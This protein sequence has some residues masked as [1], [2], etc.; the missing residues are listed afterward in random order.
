[1]PGLWQA[2][3]IMPKLHSTN[4]NSGTSSM[5]TI[6]YPSEWEAIKNLAEK[7][8]YKAIMDYA[9]Y[10]EEDPARID[11]DADPTLTHEF[12]V[13]SFAISALA[14]FPSDEITRFLI[15]KFDEY[16]DDYQKS[17]VIRAISQHGTETAK[18]FLLKLLKKDDNSIFTEAVI[19]GVDNAEITVTRE[20][21][22]LLLES[23][24]KNEEIQEF[25]GSVFEIAARSDKKL[26]AELF[27]NAFK[28][29]STVGVLS[30]DQSSLL[31][32]LVEA[33]M[34]IDY[35]IDLSILQ[36]LVEN[37]GND[38]NAGLV[39]RLVYSYPGS[40]T[41]DEFLSRLQQDYAESDYVLSEIGMGLE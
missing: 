16:Q 3:K 26:S 28:D 8:D 32:H 31:E 40:K 9:D 18:T 1:M 22:N 6:T 2:M 4:H 7:S 5:N 27:D 29:L 36:Q 12:E 15:K 21:L 33:A 30:V 23:V 41:R 25:T 39:A 20:L 10:K 17:D 11:P 13:Q 24:S 38:S 19:D 35:R 37:D 34:D 14:K